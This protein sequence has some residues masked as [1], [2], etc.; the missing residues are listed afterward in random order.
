MPFQP[1]PR[2]FFICLYDF[3]Y[4]DWSDWSVHMPLMLDQSLLAKACRPDFPNGKDVAM[5]KHQALLQLQL[6]LL[7]NK[8]ISVKYN[9]RTLHPGTTQSMPHPCICRI[10]PG[11]SKV[12]QNASLDSVLIQKAPKRHWSENREQAFWYHHELVVNQLGLPRTL[13]W[14]PLGQLHFWKLN[15]HV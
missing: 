10:I 1:Y 11:S 7:W 5:K 6:Q 9:L 13:N 3:K 12:L 15:A 2:I 8:T 4:I 14:Y